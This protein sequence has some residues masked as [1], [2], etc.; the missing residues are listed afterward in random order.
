MDPTQWIFPILLFSCIVGSTSASNSETALYVVSVIKHLE[1][2]VPGVSSCVLYRMFAADD[3]LQEVLRAPQLGSVS[4]IVITHRIGSAGLELLPVEHLLVVIEP[5]NLML[6]HQKFRQV[7]KTFSPRSKLLVLVDSISKDY[8]F[9]NLVVRQLS[10]C[11]VVYLDAKRRRMFAVDLVKRVPLDYLAHPSGLFSR[12]MMRDMHGR[13]I[14][15][16]SKKWIDSARAVWR[17]MKETAAYMNTT[18]QRSI[19]NCTISKVTVMKDLCYIEHFEKNKV[20]IDLS[21]YHINSV[22]TQ[23]FRFLF[24]GLTDDVVVLVPK[25]QLT[26]VQ[27]FTF[28]FDWEVWVLV[29]LILGAAETLRLLFPS[30]FRNDPILLVVCGFERYDLNTAGLWEKFVLLSVMEFIFF[31]TCAYE[32]KLLAMMVSKP[33]TQEIHTLQE[34]MESGIKIK[35]NFLG[36]PDAAE[37]HLLGSIM[38]NSTETILNMDKI[39]AHIVERE[40]AEL[41]LPK[42]YDPVQRLYRYSILDQSLGTIPRLYILSLRNPFKPVLEYTNA[43][44]LESG[45]ISVYWPMMIKLKAGDRVIRAAEEADET[46]LFADMKPAWMALA[47]GLALSGVVFAGEIC[48]KMVKMF[49]VMSFR[50]YLF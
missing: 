44:L 22:G 39:H 8:N 34:L 13:P 19:P 30:H 45:L 38:V 11:S 26:F 6:G 14:T 47:V 32:T 23:G 5:K 41:V 50:N 27:L 36:Y 46:L 18:L 9:C 31:T 20:D 21:E 16:V 25:S 17:W 12:S 24:T 49:A 3:V 43:A 4:K 10:F 48:V 35:V 15:F 37:N 1:A 29:A 33:A 2:T 42:Y 28:P 7:L 40:V